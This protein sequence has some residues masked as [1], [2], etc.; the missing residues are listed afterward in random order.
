MT[1]NCIHC[2]YLLNGTYND[3]CLTSDNIS[4]L[5]SVFKVGNFVIGNFDDR[6]ISCPCFGFFCQLQMVAGQQKYSQI[7][8][9][10]LGSQLGRVG[11]VGAAHLLHHLLLLHKHLLDLLHLLVQLIQVHLQ[12]RM[13]SSNV[14][15]TF[16]PTR[17]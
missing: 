2:L 3:Q 10:G 7:R 6:S 16:Q 4:A 9:L 14:Q 1:Q 17:E 5:G 8:E 11:G 12:Q 15:M 13:N